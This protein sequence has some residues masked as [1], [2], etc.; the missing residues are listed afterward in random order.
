M[1]IQINT[2]NHIKNS[3]DF[4]SELEAKVEK[5]LSKYAKHV[6]RVEVYLHDENSI[7]G[8]KDDKKCSIEVRLEGLKPL[9]ASKQAAT[10]REAFNGAADKIER[11][12][13]STIDKRR[14][15]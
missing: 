12:V 11:V 13:G 6:T 5:A 3:E 15:G 4:S 14:N 8:G 7:K 9:A 10:L 2:D 1:K